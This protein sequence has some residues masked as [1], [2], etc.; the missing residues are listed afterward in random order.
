MFEEVGMKAYVLTAGLL[1]GLLPGAA[2]AWGPEG[3]SIVAEIAQRRL[4]PEAAKQVQDLLRSE[5]PAGLTGYY[6]LASIS[7]W[8]DD[9]RPTHRE[10]THWHFVG[11]PINVDGVKQEDVRYDPVRDCAPAT[12]PLGT[13]L[14]EALKEQVAI[15]S[16]PA[17][18]GDAAA[19]AKRLM[20]LKF[21][22]HMMGDLGQPLH[23]A[24][25]DGDSGGNGLHV[26]YTGPLQQTVEI[27]TDFHKVWDTYILTDGHWNWGEYSQSLEQ[28]WLKGKDEAAIASGD[29]VSWANEC[30][31]QAV[32]AYKLVPFDLT[33]SKFQ[34]GKELA[35][36]DEQLAKSG[37]RLAALLNRILVGP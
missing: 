13:C 12:D 14:I 20:S 5:Y 4:T 31:Q 34:H 25:R 36:A 19:V 10:T 6:S 3:H 18:A 17:P 29:Y 24:E 21:V 11:I 1:A 27:H 7:S 33:L 30:H 32:K 23:C 37:V 9:Y 2:L 26:F 15:L 8:A 28:G 35:I 22:V 16:Q